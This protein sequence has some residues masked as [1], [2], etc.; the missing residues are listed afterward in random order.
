MVSPHAKRQAVRYL[1]VAHHMSERRACQVVAA[2]RSTVRYQPKGRPDDAELVTA[3]RDFAYRFPQ[4]GYRHITAWM[5]RAGYRVNHK[6]V[7]RIWQQEG[8]QLPRRTVVKRYFGV[9]RACHQQ[10][11][12]PNHVWSYDFTEDRTTQGHRLRVLAVLDEYTRTCLFVYV[13]RSIRATRLLDILHWLFTTHGVPQYLR[14][15]NGPECVAQCVQHWLA[16]QGS[17]TLYITPGSPWENP[18]IER[19]IG[20]LKAECLNR[21]L[22]DSVVTAQMI[23][24][25]YVEEYNQIR[26]HSALGYLTPVEYRQQH[27][28]QMTLTSTGT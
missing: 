24:D 25:H 1:I 10:A 19:F 22:F 23:V 17:Q 9:H 5:Q 13:A 4:H 3:V 14:S 16:E 26:P 21:Y 15:D 8:L 11:H 18:F 7:G 20:T 6:R 28:D 2:A 27:W 12:Y